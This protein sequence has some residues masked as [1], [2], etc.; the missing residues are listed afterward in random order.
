MP[1]KRKKK[2]KEPSLEVKA[3]RG[4]RKELKRI[5]VALESDNIAAVGALT[6]IVAAIGTIGENTHGLALNIQ[7]MGRADAK[8]EQ[9]LDE[10]AELRNEVRP[11][12][13]KFKAFLQE[14]VDA[15]RA[16][17]KK[18]APKKKSTKK[19]LPRKKSTRT[20]KKASSK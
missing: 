5:A 11:F 7:R 9:A 17:T 1:K 15:K 10:I 12:A 3:I 6:R 20:K 2:S 14:V 19:T 18:A 8:S 16:S 13:T 4:V